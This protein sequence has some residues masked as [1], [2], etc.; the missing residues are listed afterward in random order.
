MNEAQRLIKPPNF[1]LAAFTANIGLVGIVAV[2][3]NDNGK[4]L[5]FHL[6]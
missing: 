5:I 3:R 6:R 1:L 4:L 2:A